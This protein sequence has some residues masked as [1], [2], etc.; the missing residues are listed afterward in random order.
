MARKAP[1]EAKAHQL[2]K[3]CPQ[4]IVAYSEEYPSIPSTVTGEGWDIEQNSA[5][6]GYAYWRGYIDLSGF[7]NQDL[8]LF[9]QAIDIQKS[10][11][12]R[13]DGAPTSLPVVK[14]L[15]VISTRR[16]TTAEITAL[17]TA[18]GYLG[19]TVDLQNV[20]YGLRRTL[21]ENLQ[22]PKEY[23]TADVET[24]GSGNATA[25]DKLHWT[26]IIEFTIVGP[27][28]NLYIYPTNLLVAALTMK[29]KDLVWMERMRRSYVLQ[30]ANL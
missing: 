7:R 21:V 12:S 20:I 1:E 27:A 3:Q 4:A 28:A 10:Y 29:E 26:R 2:V 19:N 24:W 22:I 14:E 18:P 17:G 6:F 8:T 5:T 13:N 15:D 30:E 9:T 23:Q 25:M 16:L 11:M